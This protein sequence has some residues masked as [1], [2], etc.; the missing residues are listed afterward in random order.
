MTTQYASTATAGAAVLA[1]EKGLNTKAILYNSG[2]KTVAATATVVVLAKIPN[3][4]R[5]VNVREY[6]STGAT[7]APMSVGIAAS[8]SAFIS[9][10]AQKTV[11]R[12]SKGIIGYSVFVTATS[13]VQYQFLTATI[14]PTLA[15]TNVTINVAVDYLADGQ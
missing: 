5:I 2:T 10:G 14:T 9:A 13:P 6:H 15:S 3:G 11:N 1:I 7:A 8:A 4:A 12:A